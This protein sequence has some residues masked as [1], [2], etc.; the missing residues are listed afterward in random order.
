MALAGSDLANR[1]IGNGG[2]N[3]LRGS[4]GRDIMTGGDGHDRFVFRAVLDSSAPA[5]DRILDFAAGEDTIDLR[6]IDAD[7]TLDG[8]QAFALVSHFSGA[9][10][11]LRWFTCDRAGTA[12][13]LTVIEAETS[14]DGRADLKIV[15][16]GL[17]AL[18]ADDFLL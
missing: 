18:T 11:E 7:E 1:L 4:G 3:H 8:N 5:A 9:A 16:S 13:D 10:G 17:V 14:G 15:L 2:D 12:S 6:G